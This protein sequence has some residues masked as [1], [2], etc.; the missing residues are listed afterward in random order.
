MSIRT[1]SDSRTGGRTSKWL[2]SGGAFPVI[3]FVALCV[4]QASLQ[5]ARSRA[6][7][8][9]SAERM[10]AAL[11]EWGVDAPGLVPPVDEGEVDRR[12][13]Q[14]WSDDGEVRVRAARWLAARGLRAS[15]DQIAASMADPGTLRP[16]QLAHSLGK[17]GD[18]QWVDELLVAAKQRS[19]ADLRTCAAIALTHIAS[20]RAIDALI[21]LTRDDPSRMFAVR[22]LGEAGDPQALEHLRWLRR[23]AAKPSQRMT[24]ELA[25]ERVE[26]LAQPDPQPDLIQRVERSA[27]EERVDDWAL[28]HLARRA[29]S[30]SVEPLAGLLSAPE[31]DRRTRELLAAAIL[32]HGG[33]GRAALA[34][35]ADAEALEASKI[36]SSALELD[37]SLGPAQVA[38]AS[39]GASRASGAA[40]PRE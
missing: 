2:R 37:A 23:R 20:S 22:A 17:L 33:D 39:G 29:D 6:E 9:S 34:R 35:I 24:I 28:R 21:D 27:R 4:G 36:A 18:D 38:N 26:L 16:C 13:A 10:Y 11:I 40:P 12:I 14:L 1:E 32:A 3:V 15:G 19:N 5:I 30:R 8:P 31:Y 7:A 25:I